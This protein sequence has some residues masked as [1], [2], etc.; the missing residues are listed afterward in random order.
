MSVAASSVY[1]TFYEL[2]LVSQEIP[3]WIEYIP[4]SIFAPALILSGLLADRRF[5]NYKVARF[6]L[7]IL[8]IGTL[9]ISIYACLGLEL[10]NLY[11]ATIFFIIVNSLTTLGLSSFLITSLQLGLDQMPDAS[12]ANITSFVAWFVFSP[13]CWYMDQQHFILC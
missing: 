5:G 6:G 7:I 10:N 11:I 8:F 2:E 9:S 13:V 12:S 1:R 4:G 3:Y